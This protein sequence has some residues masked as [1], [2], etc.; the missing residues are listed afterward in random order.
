M[1][2]KRGTR[3]AK[4]RKIHDY[5]ID[6]FEY[7]YTYG[8]Y[9]A[10]DMLKSG[11]G[12]CYS[13]A[14]LFYKLCQKAGIPCVIV[15]GVAGSAHAWNYVKIKGKWKLVDVTYDETAKTDRYFMTSTPTT[16]KVLAGP[17]EKYKDLYR[18]AHPRFYQEFLKEIL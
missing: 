15:N 11:K 9:T 10:Y 5:L 2:L 7:D 13:F 1:K 17:Y 4:V 16:H 8:S 14:S 3:K 18:T 6:T 12:V